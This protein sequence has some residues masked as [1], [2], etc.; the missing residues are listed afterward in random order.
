MKGLS[1]IYEHSAENPKGKRPVK[2]PM[3]IWQNNIKNCLK[4]IEFE[5]VDWIN[6][7]EDTIL[8]TFL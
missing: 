2:R 4:V 3:Q 5:N 6:V 1:N 8:D 7:A